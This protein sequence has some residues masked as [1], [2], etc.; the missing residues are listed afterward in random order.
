MRCEEKIGLAK[1]YELATARFAE[2]V[3][4][5]LRNIASTT[6]MAEYD[7]LQG[8]SDEARA[9]TEQARLALEEHIAAHGC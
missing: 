5:F 8:I 1:A 3:A 2:A 7:R 4:E 6:T 9:K